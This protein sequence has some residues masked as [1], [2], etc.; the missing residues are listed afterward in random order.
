VILKW[1]RRSVVEVCALQAAS[2]L[3]IRVTRRRGKARNVKSEVRQDYERTSLKHHAVLG[4][5]I[6]RVNV[7]LLSSR[8]HIIDPLH[9]VSVAFCVLHCAVKV[10]GSCYLNMISICLRVKSFELVMLSGMLD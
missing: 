2:A 8:G 1:R 7:A 10:H 4:R 5:V 3:D 9:A 6:L